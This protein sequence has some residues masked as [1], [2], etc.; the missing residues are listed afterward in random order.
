IRELSGLGLLLDVEHDGALVL[1]ATGSIISIIVQSYF[2]V[3][4]GTGHED[5]VVQIE[6]LTVAIIIELIGAEHLAAIQHTGEVIEQLTGGGSERR[7]GHIVQSIA[8]VS[9][10]GISNVV[11]DGIGAIAKL[12]AIRGDGGALL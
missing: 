11:S 8:S 12:H 9:L 3:E 6:I 5:H 4:T 1:I 2:A 10:V 7:E